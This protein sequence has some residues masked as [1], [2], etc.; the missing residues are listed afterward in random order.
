MFLNTLSV[1]LEA[2]S[3]ILLL[4]IIVFLL[5]GPFRRY[6]LV[7]LYCALQ[8]A[9]NLSED[10]VLRVLGEPRD[11][12]RLFITLYWT[13]E[14]VLDLVL[15]LLVIAMT[16]RAL[17]GSPMRAGI[18]RFLGA[19]VLIVLVVPFVLFHS[20]RFGTG[21]Y[22]ST[23]QLLNFG[24]AIMNLGLWTALLGTKKRD[25]LLLRVSAGLGIA[26][27]GAA[28]AYGLR[29]FTT[30]GGTERDLANL[31]KATTYVASVVIWFWAFLPTARK[32]ATPPASV[33]SPT[34][35]S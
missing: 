9:A 24:A 4:G 13:D 33:S 10:Y 15:F 18:G 27:T 22:N 14:V 25:P 32:S 19:V 5:R 8:L 20:R 35:Q 30:A 7:L 23:S 16:Y 26:V 2:A 3:F 21:W 28:I 29:K 12:S 11:T 1:L 34:V 6:P 17:E 31:L